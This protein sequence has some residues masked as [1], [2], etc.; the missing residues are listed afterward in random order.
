[1]NDIKHWAPII[2][3][4]LCRYEHFKNCIESLK[5]C[6]G[7][8][9]T[10]VYI[11]LDY[12]QKVTHWD[13][14]KKIA[15]YLETIQGFN[16]LSII[17]R[18]EN[19]GAT[20]N[21][22]D[23]IKTTLTK[24]DR[25]I[26][27]EDDNIF[28]PNFLLYINQCLDYYKNDQTVFCIDGYALNLDF[29]HEDNNVFRMPTGFCAWGFASWSDKYQSFLNTDTAYYKK[30]LFRLQNLKYN[31]SLGKR[32]LSD[33]IS[34][35]QKAVYCDKGISVYTAVSRKSIIMPIISKVRNNGWD[36]SGIHC[37]D[38]SIAIRFIDQPFD[39]AQNFQLI[40]RGYLGIQENLKI[41]LDNDFYSPSWLYL[42]ARYIKRMIK[43]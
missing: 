38:S 3:P 26:Y 24:Y 41:M 27:S 8:A 18:T 9:Q 28:S 37:E 22:Q 19:L 17:T 6:P 35:S 4:T 16:S 42:S 36:G 21:T 23:L 33:L 13:G 10:D 2:I 1:M 32:H 40:D 31:I 20:V 5:K 43:F 15:A 25:F 29:K 39:Q 34:M 11:A 12:P 14:Y 7:A 30:A